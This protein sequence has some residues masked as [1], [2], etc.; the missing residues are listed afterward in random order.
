MRKACVVI[1]A[2]LA[3]AILSAPCAYAQ[4]MPAAPAAAAAEKKVY[5]CEACKVSMDT[6]GKCPVCG[7][8]LVEVVI[9]EDPAA[10]A[11]ETPKK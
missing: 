9:A 1:A 3:M 8:E 5:N 11:Q 6:P 10:P 4:D 7:M 2:I